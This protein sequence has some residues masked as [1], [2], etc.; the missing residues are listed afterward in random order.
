VIHQLGSTGVSSGLV[1][2]LMPV[3]API[4]MSYVAKQVTGS[5]GIAGSLG[6]GSLGGVLSQVLGGAAQGGGGSSSGPHP[7]GGILGDVLGGL[8]GRGTKA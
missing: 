4:V 5:G 7:M 2:K 6:S 8:L 3:L 1:G